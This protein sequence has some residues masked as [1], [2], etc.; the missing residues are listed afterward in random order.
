LQISKRTG[1]LSHFKS[2]Y[3]PGDIVEDQ[4]AEDSNDIGD[5]D[6]GSSEDTDTDT[7]DEDDVG[8]SGSSDGDGGNG[9]DEEGG[10]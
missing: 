10:T 9:E 4:I 6:T 1:E 8:N 7:T 3:D 2:K 5:T